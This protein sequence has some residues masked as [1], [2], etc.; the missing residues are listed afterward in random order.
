V[1]VT[2]DP[3][4]LSDER[5]YDV[6]VTVIACE[7]SSAMLREW[8]EQGHPYVRELAKI[9][10]VDYIDLPTGHWPQFTR[11]EELGRAILASVGPA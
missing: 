6:P 9:R 2:S 11:P 7:F 8:M 1:H 10:D 5:R 3:Q 4:Q